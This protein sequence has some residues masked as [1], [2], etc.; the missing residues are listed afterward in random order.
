MSYQVAWSTDT[1][2][3]GLLFNRLHFQA[4]VWVVE[5][6]EELA[7][8]WVDPLDSYE[9]WGGQD[10]GLGEP[11]HI[12]DGVTAL[13]VSPGWTDDHCV[14]RLVGVFDED[15]EWTVEVDLATASLPSDPVRKIE[16]DDVSAVL[17]VQAPPP[18]SVRVRVEDTTCGQYT[19][20][21]QWGV[22]R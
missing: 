14:F 20:K 16:M 5:T 3:H 4:G 9:G 10:L 12:P 7:E 8:A 22:S 19:T 21:V 15:G 11:P 6:D 17:L 2:A 1:D 18:N 13:F